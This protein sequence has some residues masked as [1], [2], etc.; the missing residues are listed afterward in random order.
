MKVTKL[1]EVIENLIE[2]RDMEPSDDS[3]RDLSIAITHLEDS[4]MRIN[5]VFARRH[6]VF[7]EVDVEREHAGDPATDTE[8]D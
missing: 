2:E 8:E 7:R 3:R 4:T 6:D 1:R 5:R